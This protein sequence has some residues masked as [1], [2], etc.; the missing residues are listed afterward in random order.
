MRELTRED[1]R[2]LNG[3]RP[4]V[5]AVQKFRDSHHRIAMLFAEGLRMREVKEI[6]GYSYPRLSVL[7]SDPA[8]QD[9]IA[10]YRPEAQARA[11]EALDEYR[12]LAVGNMVEGELMIEEVLARAREENE[13]PSIRELVAITSDRADRFGYGK[14]QTST[15]VNVDIATRLDAAIART[16][17]LIDHHKE[18]EPQAVLHSSS[19]ARARTLVAS[20][21]PIQRRRIA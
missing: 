20:L 12:A 16:E 5:S 8:F 4:K 15:N 3:P 10:S 7:H 18:V 19:H 9:L 21:P 6:T 13:L 17:K 11:R 14:H 1:L 2:A